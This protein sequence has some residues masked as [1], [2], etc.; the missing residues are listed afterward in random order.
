MARPRYPRSDGAL[1]PPLPPETRTVG[2]VVA[3]SVRFYGDRFWR[4]LALGVAPAL[5][6]IGLAAMP[7]RAELVWVL[8]FGA[9]AL[10]TSYV[11]AAL[12][13]TGTA[14]ERR[15]V[16]IAVAI[17]LV[18]FLPVPFLYSL[19]FLPAIAWL[20]LV[21]LSVPA[22]AVERL[23]A[24]RAVARGI[25]LARAD[26]VHTLGSL[27]TLAIVAFLTS[28]VIFFVVREQGE[29]ALAAAAF[30]ALLV[31]SPL[32]FVGAAFVYVDQRARAAVRDAGADIAPAESSG[33][34][35]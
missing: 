8:T 15:P 31:V 1:P 10:T 28:Y 29:A 4:T 7:D 3:E 2:Q 24:R 19:F 23:G 16:A 33:A 21:G 17:G 27:A 30:A 20:A 11:A 13:V 6:G 12:L 34:R 32:L 5:A 22:A 18:V 14:P 25:Q 26:F 35:G 9:L